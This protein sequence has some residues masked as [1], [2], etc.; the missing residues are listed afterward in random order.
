MERKLTRGEAL[1]AI[2]PTEGLPFDL[3]THQR[4]EEVTDDCGGCRSP[5]PGLRAEAEKA[6]EN[7]NG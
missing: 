7:I 1:A 2:F 4:P 6:K 5:I 3:W